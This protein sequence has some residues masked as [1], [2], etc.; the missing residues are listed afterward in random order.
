MSEPRYTDIDQPE[1]GTAEAVEVE[2]EV[3]LA[4]LNE[5]EVSQVKEALSEAEFD[6]SLD[7]VD[8]DSEIA[9]AQFAEEDRAEAEDLREEQVEAADAGDYETAREKAEAVQSELKESSEEHGGDLDSAIDSNAHDVEVLSEAEYQQETAEAFEADA[10]D[11]AEDGSDAADSVMDDAQDSAEQADD[12]AADSTDYNDT[13]GDAS[14]YT[15][16]G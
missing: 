10:E 15:D 2:Y 7:E 16:N 13:G 14:I 3:E 8:V 12:Y 5:N 1:A 4:G 6:G 11:Y 9:E